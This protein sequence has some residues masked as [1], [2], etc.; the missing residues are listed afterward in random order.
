MIGHYMTLAGAAFGA[1][2]FLLM[3]I[4]DLKNNRRRQAAFD[5]AFF[6]FNIWVFV[7]QI[8]LRA[9]PF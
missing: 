8:Y 2:L 6:V 5:A 7:F 4:R 9:H 1:V 3:L